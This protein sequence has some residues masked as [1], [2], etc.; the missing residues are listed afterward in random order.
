MDDFGAYQVAS[1]IQSLS[2]QIGQEKE[3]ARA[4]AYNSA[5][6]QKSR[7]YNTW[8]LQNETQM[9]A[10]DAR[11]AGLNPAFMNGSVLSNTPSPSSSPTSPNTFQ[12]LDPQLMLN[13]E[14]L[15]SQID[16]VDA[17]TEKVNTETEH[18]TIENKYLDA[19]MQKQIALYGSNIDLNVANT[20]LSREQ[21][22][23][24]GQAIAESEN[25][26]AKM[27]GEMNIMRKQ[28]DIMSHEEKIKSIEAAF[29]SQEMQAIIANY[30]A[31]AN[32]SNKQAA[33][34]VN[35]FVYRMYGLVSEAELNEETKNKVRWDGASA[36]LHFGLDESFAEP[37][38]II[39]MVNGSV[40]ALQGAG[41][42]VM[43]YLPVGKAAKLA[44][45]LKQIKHVQ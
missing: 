21:A 30:Q 13:N 33:D 45:G 3:N 2:N 20:N 36:K 42:V 26:I 16:N 14:L 27:V 35:T 8:L 29:K 15:K 28:V 25:R 18:N 11:K 44:G 38:R 39:G 31:S 41:Q 19:L 10:S 4:R 24:V 22:R 12:G 40:D 9:K 6:A 32:L 1:N 43:Q 37:E 23:E 17:M 5:E 34:I 7:D